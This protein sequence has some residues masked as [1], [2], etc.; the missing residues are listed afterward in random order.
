MPRPEP[1]IIHPWQG[2]FMQPAFEGFV[3]FASRNLMDDFERESGPVNLG[4][5][6]I[7]Q[8]IDAATGQRQSELQRF[9]DW[10]VTQFGTPEQI[11]DQREATA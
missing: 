8:M 1:T 7:D 6:T 3:S 10:C 9:I 11:Q 4:I 5:S 2:H